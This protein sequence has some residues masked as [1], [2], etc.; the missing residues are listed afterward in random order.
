MNAFLVPIHIENTVAE[1]GIYQKGEKYKAILMQQDSPAH[2]PFQLS[3]WKE[4]GQWKTDHLISIHVLYQFGYSID[5]QLLSA[6]IAT[7]KTVAA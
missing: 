7:L 1:Y 3:F 4:N 6:E 2:L 5:N